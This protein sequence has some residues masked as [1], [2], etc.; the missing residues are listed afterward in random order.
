MVGVIVGT[1]ASWAAVGSSVG[2]LESGSSSAWLQPINSDT[3]AKQNR[4]SNVERE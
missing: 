1:S 3:V 2:R 4:V